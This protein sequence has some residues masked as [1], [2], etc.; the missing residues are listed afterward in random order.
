M[1]MNLGSQIQFYGLRDEFLSTLDH[2]LTFYFKHYL[3]LLDLANKNTRRL[4][5]SILYCVWQLYP[6]HLGH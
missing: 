6:L 5:Q 2:Q 3:G 1:K 4:V